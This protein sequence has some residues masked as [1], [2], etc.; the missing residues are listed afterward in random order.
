MT[1]ASILLYGGLTGMFVALLVGAIRPF[2]YKPWM[3][4]GS[5]FAV[6][7]GCSLADPTQMLPW[8]I[9][10]QVGS[11]FSLLQL[12]LPRQPCLLFVAIGGVIVLMGAVQMYGL[13][14]ILDASSVLSL[15]FVLSILVLSIVS[16]RKRFKGNDPN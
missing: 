1:I 8:G 9:V 2:V 12:R 15:L 6:S 11:I 4:W 16:L 3:F 13:D 5:G 10:I 7:L 14:V